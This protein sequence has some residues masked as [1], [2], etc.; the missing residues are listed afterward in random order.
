[1]LIVVVQLVQRGMTLA[2]RVEVFTQLSCH[3]LYE[4]YNHTRV[5]HTVFNSSH[6]VVD[7]VEPHLISVHLASS[8]IHTSGKT[9]RNGDEYEDPRVIPSKKCV[10][11]PAVQAGAARLQTMMTTTMGALSA[12]TTGWWGQ[13]GERHGRIRVLAIS[14]FGLFLTYVSYFASFRGIAYRYVPSNHKETSHL[15]LYQPL[16]AP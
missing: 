6:Y 2:S 4:H 8:P 3:N 13:F 1:M 10:S 16:T 11:D 15:F 5:V 7:P 9:R 12:L 14:T